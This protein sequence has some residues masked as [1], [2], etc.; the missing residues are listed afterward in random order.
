[1]RLEKQVVSL[2]LAKRM[3][4]LGFRQRSLWWWGS[5]HE[6]W[7]FNLFNHP[8]DMNELYSAYTV[9]E[10][11]EMLPYNIVIKKRIRYYDY[12]LTINKLA[13]GYKITYENGKSIIAGI[14]EPT[15][16]N[17]KAKMLIYLKEK[18]LI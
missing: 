6:G 4:E 16:A 10:L 7:T 14:A 12:F 11:G 18:G 17:A 3:K 1:M 13:L 2:E 9:A 15:E 8:R 5:L